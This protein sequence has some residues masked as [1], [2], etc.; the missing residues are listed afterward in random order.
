MA[1][2]WRF[3]APT[4]QKVLPQVWQVDKTEVAEMGLGLTLPVDGKEDGKE[5]EEGD[6]VVVE[7]EEVD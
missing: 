2:L 4:E 1:R 7:G 6:V 5:E 3:N